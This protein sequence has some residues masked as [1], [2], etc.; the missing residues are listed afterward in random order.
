MGF[1]RWW[2]KKSQNLIGKAG[3]T[4]LGDEWEGYPEGLEMGYHIFAP[5]R[6]LGYGQ[7]SCRWIL[8]YAKEQYQ[9]PVY[10][11][12][13]R[14]NERSIHLAEMCGFQPCKMMVTE[15]KCNG[16]IRKYNPYVWN[17]PQYLK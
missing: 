13:D 2:K 5:Y 8:S 7:E 1:G 6:G 4:T 9:L 14:S 15:K 12:I 3:L 11:K 17:C 16:E 10:A